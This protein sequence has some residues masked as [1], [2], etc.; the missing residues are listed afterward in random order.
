MIQVGIPLKP[1]I[2]FLKK[3]VFEKS[4][5]KPKEAGV[6]QFEKLLHWLLHFYLSDAHSKNTFKLGIQNLIKTTHVIVLF[7]CLEITI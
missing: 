3:I 1:T 7:R 4:K 5:S 2:F 6:V